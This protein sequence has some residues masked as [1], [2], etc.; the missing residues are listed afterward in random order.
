MFPVFID[1]L[2]LWLLSSR[3][4]A[5]A[6]RL[7]SDISGRLHITDGLEVFVFPEYLSESGA[8]LETTFVISS[9]FRALV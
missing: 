3:L 6:V 1:E 8:V 7:G 2:N 9:F 5:K 4:C